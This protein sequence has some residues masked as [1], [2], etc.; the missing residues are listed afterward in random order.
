L[1]IDIKYNEI[2]SEIW[3]VF[4]SDLNQYIS[5][6][7]GEKLIKNYSGIRVLPKLQINYNFNNNIINNKTID[8]QN[9]DL[10]SIQFNSYVNQF[11]VNQT[12][13][14]KRMKSE[15]NYSFDSK[16]WKFIWVYY[17]INEIKIIK[18]NSWK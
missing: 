1:K 8:I 15:D 9:N 16:L 14:T 13:N 12:L 10:N 2:F 17:L 3:Q 18:N 7:S 11:I 6:E 4:D 5:I